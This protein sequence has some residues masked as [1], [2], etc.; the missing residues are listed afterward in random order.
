[1]TVN[2][3]LGDEITIVKGDAYITGKVNGI[4]LDKGHLQC[5]SLED[6][7]TWFWVN[8]GWKFIDDE[9]LLAEAEDDD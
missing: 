4:K 8:Q 6:I 1:V 3:F 5:V 7:P 2:I 9:E